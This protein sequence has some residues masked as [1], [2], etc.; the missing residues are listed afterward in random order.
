MDFIL[1]DKSDFHMVDYLSIA[2]DTAASR[3]LM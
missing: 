2:V 3:I 1:L